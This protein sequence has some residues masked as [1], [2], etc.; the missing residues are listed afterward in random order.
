MSNRLR[1][2]S[3]IFILQ[4][5]PEPYSLR[6]VTPP[7]RWAFPQ[8]VSYP[9]FVELR[10]EALLPLCAYFHP[11]QGRSEGVAFI[12]SPLLSVCHPQRSGRHTGFAGLARWGRN[13]L[14]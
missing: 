8:V 3:L 10:A 13:S 7:L 12:D 14:G 11:R 2:Y 9:R 5:A 1:R 6:Y 4:I